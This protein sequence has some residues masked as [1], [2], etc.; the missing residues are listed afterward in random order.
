MS[1]FHCPPNA[2]R[3]WGQGCEKI[4]SINE[5]GIVR[6]G[7]AQREEGLLCHEQFSLVA[8]LAGLLVGRR[9]G[10]YLVLSSFCNF[11]YSFYLVLS[12][13]LASKLTSIRYCGTEVKFIGFGIKIWM[14]ANM[15]C[16]SLGKLLKFSKPQFP[17]L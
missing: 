5:A 1:V 6:R 15:S 7:I 14:S 10:I 3:S 2:L 16:M 12:S 4:L 17:H 11:S 8:L 9:A 13:R